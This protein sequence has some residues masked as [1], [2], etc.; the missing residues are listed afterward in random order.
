ML[1]DILVDK[2]IPDFEGKSFKQRYDNLPSDKNSEIIL[3][4][5]L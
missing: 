2:I 5:I 4:E 1:L 3:R